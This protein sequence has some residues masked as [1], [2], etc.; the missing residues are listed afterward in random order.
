M[1]QQAGS[2]GNFVT[3]CR[4]EGFPG[5]WAVWPAPT[6]AA[7]QI[8]GGFAGFEALLMLVVPGKKWVGP[9]SPAGNVPIYWVRRC[10]V[11]VVTWFRTVMEEPS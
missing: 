7:W 8:I 4:K 11:H 6:K 3:F 2:L 10:K 9:V 1:T 5:V